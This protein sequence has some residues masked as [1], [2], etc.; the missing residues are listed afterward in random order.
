MSEAKAAATASTASSA[1]SASGTADMTGIT[2]TTSNGGSTGLGGTSSM[3]C[4]RCGG[5]FHCGVNDGHCAC[6]GLR[7]SDA[8][9]AQLAA[10]Y[11]GQCLCL[12]CLAALS[13]SA[14]ATPTPVDAPSLGRT[15]GVSD[16]GG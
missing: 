13:G 2:S 8:L 12:A 6:F 16:G 5:G 15:P 1:S 7:L 3:A 14:S 4:P 10:D 11:P 9:K